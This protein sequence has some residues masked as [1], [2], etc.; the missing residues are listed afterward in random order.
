MVAKIVLEMSSIDGP[1]DCS[2]T[3]RGMTRATQSLSR[4]SWLQQG[5]LTRCR[6]APIQS[7]AKALEKCLCPSR[8]RMTGVTG[9]SMQI[10]IVSSQALKDCPP[11]LLAPGLPSLELS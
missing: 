9:V 3:C 2:L 4:P 1:R 6:S 11:V 8:C 10:Q 7:S 5:C